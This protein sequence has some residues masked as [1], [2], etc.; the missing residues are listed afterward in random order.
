[1]SSIGI[2]RVIPW[3]TFVLIAHSA[4]AQSDPDKTIHCTIN[5]SSFWTRSAVCFALI[6]E[7]RTVNG[8]VG[9]ASRVDIVQGCAA[10]LA[11]KLPGKDQPTYL[12]ACEQLL[13]AL[14]L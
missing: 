6:D 5:S 1:M 11:R 12:N 9:R 10:D 8:K 2:G 13:G 14:H 3:I 4:L 7:A